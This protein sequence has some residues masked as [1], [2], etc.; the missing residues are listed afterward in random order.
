MNAALQAAR[1]GNYY[2]LFGLRPSFALDT[3]DLDR[4]FRKLQREV[5]PDQFTDKPAAERRQALEWASLANEAYRTLKSP[6]ER[7]RH[8]MALNAVDLERAAPKLSPAFLMEQMERREALEAAVG[9]AAALERIETELDATMDQLHGRLIVLLD[10]QR[11]FAGACEIVLRLQF[12]E[13]L[14]TELDRAFELI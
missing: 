1:P 3:A 14:R 12:Y 10:Q 7:A 9:D 5:H 6:V 4:S 2:A 11:N 8:L 13:R